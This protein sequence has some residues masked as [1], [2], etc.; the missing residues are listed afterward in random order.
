MELEPLDR[1]HQEFQFNTM[2]LIYEY[3]VYNSD[4]ELNGHNQSIHDQI[5]DD[6]TI[7][8]LIKAF[9]PQNNHTSADEIKQATHTHGVYPKGLQHRK[10]HL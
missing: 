8:A 1:I 9:R 6:E 3:E 4:N 10:F 2:P 5:N 7:K